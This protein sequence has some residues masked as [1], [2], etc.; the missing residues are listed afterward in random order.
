MKRSCS[1]GF[2][3]GKKC[4]ARLVNM[5]RARDEIRFRGQDVAVFPDARDLAGLFELPQHLI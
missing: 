3:R 2:S 1:P 4:V 5:Q